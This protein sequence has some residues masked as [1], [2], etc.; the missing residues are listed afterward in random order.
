MRGRV[1]VQRCFFGALLFVV[2]TVA[3][4]HAGGRTPEP[5]PHVD[6]PY[7]SPY[8]AAGE[9]APWVDEV[10]GS[11]SLDLLGLAGRLFNAAQAIQ[12]FSGDMQRLQGVMAGAAQV[13]NVAPRDVARALDV[14][15]PRLRAT[16]LDLDQ[17]VALVTTLQ[18]GGGSAAE[19]GGDLEQLGAILEQPDHRAWETLARQGVERAQVASAEALLEH[20]QGL[21]DELA[22]EVIDAFGDRAGRLLQRLTDRGLDR[23]RERVGLLQGAAMAS[24]SDALGGVSR[25]A[26]GR[27]IG[28]SGGRSLAG[29][30]AQG[31]GDDVLSGVGRV[32]QSSLSDQAVQAGHALGPMA[33]AFGDLNRSHRRLTVTPELMASLRGQADR[34]FDDLDA[35]LVHTMANYRRHRDFARA[36]E[37]M[38][39]LYPE[40]EGRMGA[41]HGRAQELIIAEWQRM[42]QRMELDWESF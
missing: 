38:V 9:L 3:S 14:A 2:L 23:L 27:S 28:G 19:I 39:L 1:L 40:A 29:L 31:G 21:S 16:G 11:S 17:T 4:L 33:A 41:A 20:L 34:S 13:S 24:G 37:A 15:G 7:L 30:L 6:G 12:G 22:A 18:E 26:V 32:L 35:V 5:L 25:A 10:I 8:T 42:Q 36:S